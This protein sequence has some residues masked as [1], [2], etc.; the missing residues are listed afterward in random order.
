MIPAA[1]G[2]LGFR[3]LMSGGVMHVSSIIRS[4]PM[5]EGVF[6]YGTI[7]YR[8]VWNEWYGMVWYGMVMV[9]RRCEVLTEYGTKRS[10]TIRD[11]TLLIPAVQRLR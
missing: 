11:N 5:K 1:A 4:H 6:L 3:A 10:R 2:N 7:P 8:M 9:F